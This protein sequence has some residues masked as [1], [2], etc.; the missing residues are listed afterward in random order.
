MLKTIRIK[1]GNS[2]GTPNAQSAL[3]SIR[4]RVFINAY[5]CVFVCVFGDVCLGILCV[6]EM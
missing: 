5:T 6:I 4:Y 1:R 3:S 2:V